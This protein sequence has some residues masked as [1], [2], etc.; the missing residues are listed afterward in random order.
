M[1]A[2]LRKRPTCCVTAKRRDG[3]SP[4]IIKLGEPPPRSIAAERLLP[5]GKEIA[6]FVNLGGHEFGDVLGRHFLAGGGDRAKVVHASLQG[7]ARDRGAERSVES[8]D[9][10][11]GCSFRRE[12]AVPTLLLEV[13]QTGLGGSRHI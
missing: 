8:R 4:D 7:V 9:N 10:R 5:F 3:P 11:L 1:S 12:Q 6:E 2:S 13:R